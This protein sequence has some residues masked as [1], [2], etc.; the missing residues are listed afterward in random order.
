MPRNGG[1][2]G[3]KDE[4]KDNLGNL[5]MELSATLYHRVDVLVIEAVKV[6]AR[7]ETKLHRFKPHGRSPIERF[8]E[9]FRRGKNDVPASVVPRIGVV[10]IRGTAGNLQAVCGLGVKDK[11]MFPY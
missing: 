2:K 8:N 6:H 11:K 10:D 9:I 7:E 5:D 1:W 4:G 3:L